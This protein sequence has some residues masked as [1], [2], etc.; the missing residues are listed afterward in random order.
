[1]LIADS[2]AAAYFSGV[3]LSVKSDY[4]ARAV[5]W[6]SRYYQ[7][8]GARRVEDMATEQGIPPNYLVQILIELKSKQI[9]RSQRGKEGGYLLARPPAEITLGDVLRCVH[10]QVFD[11]PALSDPQC[12]VELKEAWLKL[13]STVNEAADAITFQHLL[14]AGSDKE[15]MYYI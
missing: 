8:G 6:L 12:P 13:Q 9:V 10:G 4:A 15:K 11:T 1:L 14:E 5:L 2:P 7:E 3:K